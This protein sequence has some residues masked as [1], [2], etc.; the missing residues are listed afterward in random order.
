MGFHSHFVWGGGGGVAVLKFSTGRQQVTV[1]LHFHAAFVNT[2][3]KF[4]KVFKCK[5]A[6]V[7]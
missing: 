6:E 7:C 3:Y 5:Q 4:Y 2:I 1:I